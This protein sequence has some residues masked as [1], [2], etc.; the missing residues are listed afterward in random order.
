MNYQPFHHKYRPQTL[1]DLIGQNAIATTLTN[2]ITLSKIA[3]AYLF[4]GSR[5]TGKTSTGRI[6]AKS[7]NCVKD[8]KPTVTPCGE[9]NSCKSIANGSS[10]DVIELDAASNNSA[11]GIRDIVS[12]TQ[13]APIGRRYK[14]WIIDEAHALSS[15]ATQVLLKTLEEPPI[16]VIFILCTTDPSKLGDT[17]ISR[18]QRFNF[19]RFNNDVI[20]NQLEAIAQSEDINISYEAL[21]LIA[22]HS[23]GGMRDATCL[24]EQVSLLSDN[25]TP[26]EVH[27]LLGTISEDNLFELLNAIALSKTEPIIR[28][29]KQLYADGKDP[30]VILQQLLEFYTNALITLENPKSPLNTLTSTTTQ[31]IKELALNSN[32]VLNHQQHLRSCETQ[33]KFSRL[34]RVML[35]VAI[36]GLLVQPTEVKIPLSSNGTKSSPKTTVNSELIWT[37]VINLQTPTIKALLNQQTKLI[38]YDGETATISTPNE[39]FRQKVEANRFPIKMGFQKVT[40]KMIDIAIN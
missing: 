14:I 40:G 38:D 5:G 7:L 27:Q 39:I 29:I 21:L 20:V 30:L 4:T 35:E 33:I 18:C 31:R 11:E 16:N 13:F 25:V 23:Q 28:I 32:T 15:A 9:C 24:L 37:Q 6:L 17:I 2:A 10:L 3:P 36:L 34:P 22:K 19:K 12:S 8:N 1:N 26:V